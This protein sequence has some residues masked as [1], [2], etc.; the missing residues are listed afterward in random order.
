MVI[1]SQQSIL[2]LS[3]PRPDW[4]AFLDALL[5]EHFTGRTALAEFA[6]HPRLAR[7]IVTDLLERE[8]VEPRAGD[9]SS[10]IEY[11]SNLAELHFRLGYDCI[12][13]EIDCHLPKITEARSARADHL[14]GLPTCSLPGGRGLLRRW[15]QLTDYPWPS[16]SDADLFAL[17]HLSRVLPEGMGILVGLEGGLLEHLAGLMGFEG[18]CEN[19]YDQ[20]GLV[21]ALAER[22]GEVM[23]GFYERMLTIDRV[24]GIWAADEFASAGGPLVGPEHLREFVLPWH[25]R[26]AR[27]AHD[28]HRPYLLNVFGRVDVIMPDLLDSVRIDARGGFDTHVCPAGAFQKRWGARCGVLGVLD[29][30]Q[31][32]E[33]SPQ[34]VRQIVRE[35]IEQVSLRGGFAIGSGSGLT[36]RV[37]P[38]NLLALAEETLRSRPDFAQ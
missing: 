11:W 19:L 31:L 2:P 23:A 1:E 9:R 13:L 24:V 3:R 21:I 32:A 30:E 16:V 7:P 6:I 17:E 33:A 20:P 10:Q 38:E 25:R 18:I 26:F 37:N 27:L 36:D 14:V 4:R 12:R 29:S 8:W 34:Q 5:G 22:V 28:A 15:D 35:A